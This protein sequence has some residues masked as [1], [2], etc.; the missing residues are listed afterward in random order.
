MP[1]TKHNYL[2]S[3][4]NDLARVMHEAF[5]VAT[6]GRP[7]PVLVDIPKDVILGEGPYIGPDNIQPRNYKPKT[8][9]DRA[10]I[11]EAVELLASAKKPIIY[12]CL[13]YT[14]DAADE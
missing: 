14:S 5:Y 11:K 12:V 9:G 4:T 8:R 7:G 13:L 1:V 10:K 3:S 2:V 6:H